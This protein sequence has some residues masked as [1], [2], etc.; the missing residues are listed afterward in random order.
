M[1]VSVLM[2]DPT[3]WTQAAKNG[4]KHPASFEWMVLAQSFDLLYAVNSKNKTKPLPR[5]WPDANAK[6]SGK[7]AVE[8][9]RVREIL[10]AMRPKE[11]D[12]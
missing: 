5:P 3:S 11:T 6:R 9:S 7:P 4:W 8:E 10:D 1:L 12:G 2:R